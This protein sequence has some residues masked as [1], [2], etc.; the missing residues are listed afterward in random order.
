MS[1]SEDI[2]GKRFG[3]LVVIEK[4][5]LTNNHRNM[6]WKCVCDCG[7]T[8]NVIGANLRNGT[9]KTCGRTLK[10]RESRKKCYRSFRVFQLLPW[11]GGLTAAFSQ[12]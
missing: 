1:K 8:V 6:R 12:A 2:S 7:G 9:T 11:V 5:G 3:R 4:H 10:K